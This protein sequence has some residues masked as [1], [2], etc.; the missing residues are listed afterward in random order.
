MYHSILI[1]STVSII[2][3]LLCNAVALHH[4]SLLLVVSMYSVLVAEY[5]VGMLLGLR[6]LLTSRISYCLAVYPIGGL[7]VLLGVTYLLSSCSFVLPTLH[8]VSLRC[9]LSPLLCLCVL[10]HWCSP[11]TRAVGYWV[12]AILLG[13]SYSSLVSYSW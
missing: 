3:L 12:V 4:P 13:C 2:L 1:L 11:A 8:S 7:L 5:F 10:R 6:Y 9:T